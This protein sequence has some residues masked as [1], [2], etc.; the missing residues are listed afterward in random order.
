MRISKDM[1]CLPDWPRLMTAEEAA[2]YLSISANTLRAHVPIEP[3]RIGGCVRYDRK[4]LDDYADG[5]PS[6]DQA[7][8]WADE[9]FG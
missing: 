7:A 8:T 1:S 5:D 2:A 6:P 9:L 3:F 4:K